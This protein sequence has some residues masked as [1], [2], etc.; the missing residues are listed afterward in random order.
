MI[1]NSNL[2]TGLFVIGV[3]IVV[4]GVAFFSYYAGF[5][6]GQLEELCPDGTLYAEGSRI[7]C[8]DEPPITFSN[9]NDLF[10]LNFSIN[11]ST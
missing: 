4:L 11:L 10:M 8:L 1:K 5:T 9:E 7:V 2:L 6:N 3:V